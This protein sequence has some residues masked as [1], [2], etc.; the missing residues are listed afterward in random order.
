LPRIDVAVDADGWPEESVL[1]AVAET[2]VRAAI[3]AA[4]LQMPA[5]AELSLLFTS[6]AQMQNLNRQ[7][8][9][10]DKP[11]NVLSFPGA[12][13]GMGEMADEVLGDIVLAFETVAGEAKTEGIVFEHHVAHL[14]IHGMLHLF[15]YDHIKDDEAVQMEALETRALA[16]LD[17]ADP[18]AAGRGN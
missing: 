18:H 16:M 17:I 12:D 14:I 8:R 5:A 1:Q 6:D 9:G 11:T 2:A 3:E 10:K 4:E 15:G 13:I 7:W